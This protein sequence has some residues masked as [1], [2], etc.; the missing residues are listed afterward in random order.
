VDRKVIL[1]AV[2]LFCFAGV[3]ELTAQ[4]LPAPRAPQRVRATQVEPLLP[5]A[6]IVAR[7]YGDP[8]TLLQ[9]DWI[10]DF[11]PDTERINSPSFE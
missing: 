6:R 2:C 10:P 5:N 1:A 9:E 3:F 4:Q 8:G 11:D 7:R